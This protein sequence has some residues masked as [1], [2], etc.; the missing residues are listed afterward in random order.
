MCTPG[1][2]GGDTCFLLSF[3]QFIYFSQGWFFNY[4]IP[5]NPSRLYL[6]RFSNRLTKSTQEGLQPGGSYFS[7]ILA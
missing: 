5:L 6:F 4:Y 1:T 3:A 7:L 2:K